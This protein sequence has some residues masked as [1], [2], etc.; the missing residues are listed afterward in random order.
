MSYSTLIILLTAILGV[1][2]VIMRHSV[3]KRELSSEI[4]SAY[5]EMKW[6]HEESLKTTFY[7]K[8]MIS[9]EGIRK[10]LIDDITITEDDNHDRMSMSYNG[11]SI[12]M[13]PD[14]VDMFREEFIKIRYYSTYDIKPV[15]E[16]S[17]CF[18][19]AETLE[20]MSLNP[21]YY[22]GRPIVKDVS[23]YSKLSNPNYQGDSPMV[24]ERLTK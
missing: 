12:T 5:L 9:D 10:G 14:D 23:D 8:G 13:H 19:V 21:D 15:S 1:V 20:R 2:F 11:L 7:L 24:Y 6:R 18:K 17:P 16:I 4:N 22:S 3:V